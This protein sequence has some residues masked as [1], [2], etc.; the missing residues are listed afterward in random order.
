MRKFEASVTT[1]RKC[2]YENGVRMKYVPLQDWT[3]EEIDDY[4]KRYCKNFRAKARRQT[5]R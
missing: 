4:L 5:Q 1:I 3:K 2:Y